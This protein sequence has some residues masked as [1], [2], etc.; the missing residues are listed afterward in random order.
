M[1]PSDTRKD[2][3]RIGTPLWIKTPHSRVQASKRIAKNHA[4]VV[5]VGAGISGALTAEALS[6]QGLNVLI[7][8]RRPAV[9]GSTPASTA[10]I[11]HEIDTP[12]T[13][14]QEQIGV[15]AANAAW[16]RSVRAVHD[17]VALAGDL[18]IA[19]SMETKPALY[20]AGNSMG[21]RAMKAESEARLKIG[22]EA[23]Y[24]NKGELLARYGLD[25][26][27]AVLSQAS[28]SANPAQLTAGLLKAALGRKARLVS[29]VEVTD[30]AQ[31]NGAVALATRDGQVI[32][33]GHAVFCTGY[34]YLRQMQTPS[35][36]VTSTWALASR[37]LKHLPEWMKS[38][39]GWEASDPYLYFRTDPA[40]RI[41]AGGEDEEAA[42]TNSDPEKL[43]AKAKI[44]AEKLFSLTGVRVGRP[45]Y[46][47]A[48]PFSVTRDGLPIID[49]VPG[50]DRIFAVMGFGGNGITFSM[51]GAQIV[52][53]W[54]AG[55]GDPDQ[56]IFRFR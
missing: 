3:L 36:H 34:E 20:L 11:Q 13:R 23:E 46:T 4:D 1:E 53:A 15:R 42:T 9:R 39:I 30:M 2:D 45:A 29:P 17:L 16:L 24:L 55:E 27:A 47:W 33:A 10:M 21:A 54:I 7:L 38:T 5:V 32:M 48:A 19:C 43:E 22:I 44:I 8:D 35:H 25:R 40:G 12:L 26:P 50:F 14:L 51:I 52:A 28:A 56:A 6:R 37:P 31:M 18:G 49:R 41:I